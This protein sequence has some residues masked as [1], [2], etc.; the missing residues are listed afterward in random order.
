[1]NNKKD[2]VL[3]CS[4]CGKS[5]REVKK[6]VAGPSVY[7]CEECISLC[8]E[9]IASDEEGAAFES[10]K[11]ELLKPSEIKAVLDS[12]IIGQ[13]RAKKVLSVAVHNHFKRIFS[14]LDTSD[15]ELQKSNILLIGP[16]GSGKT[17]LA[18]SLANLLH[19]PFTI[20][21]ATCLT[22]A[23]YVGEDVESII[24]NLLNAANGDVKL[25]ERG[26]VYIDEI[27]K[28]TRRGE[29][30]S[31]TRDVSGE[32]VQQALLK[33]IEGSVCNVPPRGGRKHPHQ[34]LIKV[35]TS[36]ILFICG[37]A[38]SGLENVIASRIGKKGLGFGSTHKNQ[39]KKVNLAHEVTTQDL[40]RFGLIPEFI[41]RLPVWAVLDA[42][43]EEAL[44]K[45]LEEPKNSITKQ[46]CRLFEL[47]GVQL[48]FTKEALIAAAR[49]ACEKKTGAR[50]LRGIFESAML[51]VMF[52]IP[53]QEGVREV[54]FNER[55]ILKKEPPLI[56]MGEKNTAKKKN[57]DKK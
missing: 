36:Q 22:E 13:E 45:V 42:L 2:A 50:G 31:I 4:F 48:R 33:I 12:H 46:Y 19:V 54:V 38:F 37:G 24:A 29:N 3:L 17:L 56:V 28:I 43:D 9:I 51:N 30:P 53:S 8:N 32:G 16:T 52:D 10:K 15:V 55:A 49:K 34:E 26:I 23:G 18:Q 7:I 39:E 41:G 35:D 25:A 27:D 20:A 57:E 6:M 14:P 40:L 1:M 11:P 21:D 47:D 5:Q 44:I